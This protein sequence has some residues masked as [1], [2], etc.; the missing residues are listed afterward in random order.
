M[1][2]HASIYGYTRCFQIYKSN[3]IACHNIIIFGLNLA[4]LDAVWRSYLWFVNFF[5]RDV[6]ICVFFCFDHV[7]YIIT[8]YVNE[9]LLKINNSREY[10]I[11]W[12][13]LIFMQKVK[14]FCLWHF[15][16]HEIPK[17]I[18]STSKVRHYFIMIYSGQETYIKFIYILK[19]YLTGWL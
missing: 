12:H 10:I 16:I 5:R 7:C 1:K 15:Y 8:R 9:E 18:P 4:H 2:Q 13:F 6:S 3:A 14:L 11:P 19:N 17:I